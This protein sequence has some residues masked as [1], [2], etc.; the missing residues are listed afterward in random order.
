MRAARVICLTL[1]RLTAALAACFAWANTGKRI[2]ARMAMIAMTTRSSMRVNARLV[3]DRTVLESLR[4]DG[5]SMKITSVEC[6]HRRETLNNGCSI[7][8]GHAESAKMKSTTF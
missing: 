3:D 7:Q 2:A 4:D 8:T 6:T 5:W 1:L